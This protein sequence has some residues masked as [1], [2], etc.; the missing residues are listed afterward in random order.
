[1]LAS[2]RTTPEMKTKTRDRERAV[3]SED[4]RNSK[5][6]FDELPTPSTSEARAEASE[7]PVGWTSGSDCTDT[8]WEDGE[9]AAAVEVAAMDSFLENLV[10][11]PVDGLVG[12]AAF[13]EDC[14]GALSGEERSQ[15]ELSACGLVKNG[16]RW[17]DGASSSRATASGKDVTPTALGETEEER[18]KRL[19]RNRESAQNSRERK[20]EYVSDLEKRARALEQ[21]NM[22]L[23]TMVINLTNENHALR[24]NLQSAGYSVPAM[25]VPCVYQT[26]TPK[27]PL[28]PMNVQDTELTDPP[29]PVPLEKKPAKRRRQTVVA[30]ATAAMLGVMSVVG[31]V[32]RDAAPTNRVPEHSVSRRLLALSGSPVEEHLVKVGINV[33]SLREEMV[34]NDDERS[35]ALPDSTSSGEVSLWGDITSDGRVVNVLKPT[36]AK[37][38][39]FSAFNAAGMQNHVN[40]FSR[41]SCTELFKFTGA[42]EGGVVA[43]REAETSAWKDEESRQKMERKKYTGAIPMLSGKENSTSF[44]DGGHEEI[45]ENSLVSVLL[46]PP[47]EGVMQQLSKLFVVTYNKRTADYTT[48]SCLMPQPMTT[49]HRHM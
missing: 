43:A 38:P 21:Q 29:S 22:E 1:M 14:F 24:V 40:L 31:L 41:V 48:H 28:P 42:N 15:Q 20:K 39:W 45:D 27:I 16:E 26:M 8:P 10:D 5:I 44:S 36:D 17:E 37:D 23:Q 30:S 49:A 32:S 4:E 12:D 47:I 35:F 25:M 13:L 18:R 9:S 34:K 6:F 2:A 33:T 19:D 3:V 46:P 7:K 11:L